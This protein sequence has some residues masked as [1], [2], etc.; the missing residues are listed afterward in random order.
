M[1]SRLPNRREAPGAEAGRVSRAKTPRR[2]GEPDRE[3]P[4]YQELPSGPAHDPS[5]SRAKTPSRGG[6]PDRGR[7]VAFSAPPRLRARIPGEGTRFRERPAHQELRSGP[8][9][10]PGE[11]R[12]RTPRRGGEPDRER[13]IA[14][15]APPRLRARIPGGFSRDRVGVDQWLKANSRELRRAQTRSSTASARSSARRSTSVQVVRSPGSGN[16]ENARR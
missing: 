7:P 10:D 4:A 8:A 12:A 5:E 2:G 1:R 11:P 6:E 16:R 13:P 15:S 14:F 9:H 3:R